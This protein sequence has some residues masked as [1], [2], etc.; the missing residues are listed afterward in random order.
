MKRQVIRLA[1]V[2]LMGSLAAG[3]AWAAGG[4]RGGSRMRGAAGGRISAGPPRI[5]TPTFSGPK[6]SGPK[7]N[8]PKLSGSGLG[9]QFKPPKQ[10]TPPKFGTGNFGQGNFGQGGFQQN[11]KQH[12]GTGSMG[13]AAGALQQNAAAWTG[14]HGKPFSP[15]WYAAHPNVWKLTHPYAGAA[16]VAVGAA[17][18]ARWFAAPYP[19]AGYSTTTSTSTETATD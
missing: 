12:F 2:C 18:V 13:A 7:L 9:G 3:E 5:G 6:L 16:T 19:Y 17:A 11:V 4:R 14:P 8:A 15:Q 10:F 1:V